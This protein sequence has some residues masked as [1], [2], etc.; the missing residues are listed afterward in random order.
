MPC[1]RPRS[2]RR[3]RWTPRASPWDCKACHRRAWA[4]GRCGARANG[5][6]APAWA[7]IEAVGLTERAHILAGRLSH[8]EKRALEIAAASEGT[9]DPT[10]SPL[11][12][13]W[14][15]GAHAGDVGAQLGAGGGGLLG[16]GL[17]LGGDRTLHGADLLLVAFA[18][19]AD[20]RAQRRGG[21]GS[22][23]EPAGRRG[24]RGGGGL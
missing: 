17:E 9:F 1:W 5:W 7:A 20:F 22:G 16:E 21:G 10:V 3:W 11:V 2:R 13:A 4:V 18:Q 6:R 12:A 24:G 23:R 15:F 19:G 8:G 14:G